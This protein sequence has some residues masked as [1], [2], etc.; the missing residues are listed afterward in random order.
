ME[1]VRTVENDVLSRH[2]AFDYQKV[3]H[4]AA[5]GSK[6]HLENMEAMAVDVV[7]CI[8]TAKFN[9]QNVKCCRGL[10]KQLYDDEIK[11]KK[12]LALSED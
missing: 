10:S 11:F 1:R 5:V 9:K 12:F 8:K 3:Y 6:E 7:R 2:G 4:D